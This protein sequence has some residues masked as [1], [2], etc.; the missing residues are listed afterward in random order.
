MHMHI[1]ID[2]GT[3]WLYGRVVTSLVKVSLLK[4]PCE[5]LCILQ[6]QSQI[7]LRRLDYIY[8][9]HSHV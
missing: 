8:T 9:S 2:M 5:E 7:Y 3:L 4:T 1:D 6:Q